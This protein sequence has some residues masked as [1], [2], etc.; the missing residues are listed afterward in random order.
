MQELAIFTRW[1]EKH[2]LRNSDSDL[3]RV[4]GKEPETTFH[5]LAGC[6]NLAGK[7]YLDRHNTVARYLH[8]EIC[9]AYGIPTPKKWHMH[10]PPE[11]IMNSNVELI[12]DMVLNTDRAIGANR[13]DIVIRDKSK[14]QVF[15]IDVSCPSDVNV[16][17][18]ENEK[19]SK[20]SALRVELGKMW[21]SEC[22]VIPVVIGGLGAVSMKFQDHL[23]RIPAIISE[24]MCIKLS[25]L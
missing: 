23:K 12:W 6:D 11:V 16:N 7:E 19:I 8:F 18:K 20:Y 10:N 17:A 22:I 1:H 13:P 14:K 15:V 4:C 24:V 25:L 2:I 5:I 9:K 3:C 21:K